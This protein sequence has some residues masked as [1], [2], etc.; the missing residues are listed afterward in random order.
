MP[1]K[2]SQLQIHDVSIHCFLNIFLFLFYLFEFT[3]SLLWAFYELIFINW[4]VLIISGIFTFSFQR[5][6]MTFL[7]IIY[8][9][10]FNVKK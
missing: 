9:K 2:I 1:A 7:W 5:D 10:F 4:N 8:L 3:C 6:P